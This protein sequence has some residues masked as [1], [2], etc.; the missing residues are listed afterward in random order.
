MNLN[1][2]PQYEVKDLGV[3]IKKSQILP[4]SIVETIVTNLNDFDKISKGYVKSTNNNITKKNSLEFQFRL[5]KDPGYNYS[6][7]FS[8]LVGKI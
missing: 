1:V 6:V 4:T 5:K 3:Y 8:F 7:A 2:L